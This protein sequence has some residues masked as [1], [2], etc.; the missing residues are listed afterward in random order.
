[1]DLGFAYHTL[2][3]NRILGFVDVL[4]MKFIRNMLAGVAG[5][6]L[7]LL[8]VAADDGV[9]P[10]TREHLAILSLMDIRQY[11]VAL[12]KIDRV[13]SGRV[14]DVADQVDELLTAKA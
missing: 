2:P 10:Q 9:M 14:D 1:M 4:A 3:D 5:I 7:G 12:T 8:V 11:I 13:S 6:D